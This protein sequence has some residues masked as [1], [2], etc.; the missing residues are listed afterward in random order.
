ME[1]T[2]IEI[3]EGE[4]HPMWLQVKISKKIFGEMYGRTEF[5]KNKDDL[6]FLEPGSGRD[7]AGAILNK[8]RFNPG[9]YGIDVISTDQFIL[10]VRKITPK[11]KDRLIEVLSD[12]FGQ[13]K[14]T[15][16]VKERIVLV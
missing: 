5:V 2:V 16:T 8:F 13:K 12:F 6:K 10:S 1:K 4:F 14:D 3:R 9:F 11:V 7:F 15:H